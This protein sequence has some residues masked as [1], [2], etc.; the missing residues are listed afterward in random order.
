MKCETTTQRHIAQF[1]PQDGQKLE[2]E[3]ALPLFESYE[4][5]ACVDGGVPFALYVAVPHKQDPM[6]KTIFTALGEEL[7]PRRLLFA[8][9]SAHRWMTEWGTYRRLEA[10]CFSDRP[11]E[12]FWCRRVLGLQLEGILRQYDDEGHSLYC[13]SWVNDGN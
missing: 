2:F 1:R 6:K 9:K 12:I 7:G 8:A 11:D 13:F 3:E 4:G 5:I 10:F